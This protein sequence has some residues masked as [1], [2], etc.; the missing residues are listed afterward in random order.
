MPAITLGALVTRYQAHCRDDHP[1]T[2]A[3]DARVLEVFRDRLG[4]AT[5]IDTITAWQIT[6]WR[7]SRVTTGKDQRARTR[8]TV[9]R[10]MHTIRG[11][12]STAVKWQ[13]DTG[14]RGNPCAAIAPLKFHEKPIRIATA[15]KLALLQTAPAVVRLLCTLTITSL[16]R[17]MEI[18]RLDP[19]RLET[20]A[21]AGDRGAAQ[22]GETPAAGGSPQDQMA[23]LQGFVTQ[24]TQRYVFFGDDVPSQQ[25]LTNQIRRWWIAQ[26]VR[27]VSHHT[28]RHTGVTA[29][30][31][32]G[33]H[34]R[35]IQE[36]AGWSSLRMLERYG[37]VTDAERNGRSTRRRRSW[38]RRSRCPHKSASANQRRSRH[39][40]RWRDEGT[41]CAVSKP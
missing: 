16:G 1:A 38:R 22:R 31:E 25:T 33:I 11:L 37:H 2:A 4:A 41:L 19:G 35:M 34:S 8:Q 39:G 40:R 24:P 18:A 3:R 10:D 5:P 27:G 28:M 6:A 9:E 7:A 21:E 17:L 12:F 26:G 23:E 15:D 29:M 30:L 13:A 14:L 20:G 32:R 36:L